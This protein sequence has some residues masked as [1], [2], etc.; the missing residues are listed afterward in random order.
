MPKISIWALRL[1]CFHLAV[2]L[3][4]GALLLAHKG[5]AFLPDSGRWFS[6]HFHTMLFGWTIQL[7]IGVAYWILPTFGGRSNRGND[8]LAVAA[9][10]LVNAGTLVGCFAAL[11][12]TT[13]TVAFSM[14]AAAALSFALHLW[15]RVKAFGT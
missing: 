12:G 15:P 8:A 9:I 11:F 10:V 6:V 4:A 2:G 1:A 7:V 14:Q 3:S 5:V 13:A